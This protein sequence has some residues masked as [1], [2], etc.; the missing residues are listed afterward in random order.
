MSRDRLYIE[1]MLDAIE[2]IED[3]LKDVNRK[4]FMEDKLI[5]DGVIREIEIIGEAAKR[6]SDS[7]KGKYPDI[8]WKD[9]CGMRD[10]LIHDY[11]GVDL[12]DVWRTAQEDLGDLKNVL[13]KC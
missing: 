10:R 1:H 9:V 4:D 13:T 5:Q 7:L 3:F 12:D 6:L 2:V 11:F 8:P